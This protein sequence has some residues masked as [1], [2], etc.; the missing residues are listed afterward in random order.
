[1][2]DF[3]ILS[4]PLHLLAGILYKRNFSCLPGLFNFPEVGFVRQKQY[5]Y[6]FPF[7]YQ[8]SE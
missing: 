5:K 8:C 6:L 4:P 1:M 7:N 3:L 2:V